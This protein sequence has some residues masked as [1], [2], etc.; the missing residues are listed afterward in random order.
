MTMPKNTVLQR[1]LRTGYFSD[2]PQS[3]LDVL[4]VKPSLR[5]SRQPASAWRQPKYLKGVGRDGNYYRLKIPPR[6]RPL[7]NI[8]KFPKGSQQRAP[9]PL[10][11]PPPP[12]QSV[13][14]VTEILTYKRRLFKWLLGNI[15]VLILNFGR[16]VIFV[17]RTNLVLTSKDLEA[18]FDPSFCSFFPYLE[19]DFLVRARYLRL[20]DPISWSSVPFP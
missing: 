17:R 4:R 10:S 16:Y 9:K 18:N 3:V 13:E 19:L 8:P 11:P 14:S 5:F 1:F 12:P 6:K 7:P 2:I 15:P 20:L